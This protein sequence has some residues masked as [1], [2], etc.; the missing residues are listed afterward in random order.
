MEPSIAENRRRHEA[1]GNVDFLV[2]DV[3]ELQQVRQGAVHA[4]GSQEMHPR[5]SNCN[6]QSVA[7]FITAYL[8]Y[9]SQ[10]MQIVDFAACAGLRQS[11]EGQPCKGQSGAGRTACLA[12]QWFQQPMQQQQQRAVHCLFLFDQL[13]A[14]GGIMPLADFAL[15][16]VAAA[17]MC[18][19]VRVLWRAAD[20][21]L[22][23]CVQQLAADVPVRSGGAGAGSQGAQLGESSMSHQL[24]DDDASQLPRQHFSLTIDCRAATA[25]LSITC[26]Q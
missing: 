8:A 2:A 23:C 15:S 11:C 17:C 22:R 3:T 25:Q 19:C 16:A 12:Q 13:Q 6:P 4:A 18:C 21:P 20:R 24:A 14:E 5:A 26:E 9:H 1:L 7:A 10:Q